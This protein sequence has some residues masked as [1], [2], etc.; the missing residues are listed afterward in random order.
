MEYE[1]RGAVVLR[2]VVL[3]VDKAALAAAPAVGALVAMDDGRSLR[4]A[5]VS[6]GTHDTAWTL[7]C[8]DAKK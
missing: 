3:R 8:E 4:V 5:S 1:D 7:H 2:R 6:P